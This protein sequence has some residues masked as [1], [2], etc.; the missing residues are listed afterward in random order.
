MVEVEDEFRSRLSPRVRCAAAAAEAS[1]DHKKRPMPGA[2][3]ACVRGGVK[4][5]SRTAQSY[6]FPA[7]TPAHWNRGRKCKADAC[8]VCCRK[9]GP[10]QPST[11]FYMQ[12]SWSH[13]GC[14]ALQLYSS[15]YASTALQL[16]SALHST[17]S[18]APSL[19]GA[20]RLPRSERSYWSEYSTS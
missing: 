5:A 6:L 8:R 12:L 11:C 4:I 1:N 13:V 10:L 17:T 7:S 2:R 19:C 16:Y 14:R 9:S 20:A 18:A 15:R 3:G